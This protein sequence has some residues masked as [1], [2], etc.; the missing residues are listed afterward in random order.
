MSWREALL[1]AFGRVAI[2]TALVLLALAAAANDEERL[3][4]GPQA[5]EAC[6][7]AHAAW[8]QAGRPPEQPRPSILDE[9]WCYRALNEMAVTGSP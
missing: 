7:G 9:Q 1:L 5:L 3:L 8:V 2:A 6:F 4:I